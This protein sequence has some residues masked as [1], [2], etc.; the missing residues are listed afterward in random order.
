[1]LK[2][3]LR[4]RHCRSQHWWSPSSALDAALS[5]LYAS[6]HLSLTTTVTVV[7]TVIIVSLQMRKLRLKEGD[8]TENWLQ[9]RLPPVSS[10]PTGKEQLLSQNNSLMCHNW[11]NRGCTEERGVFWKSQREFEKCTMWG[12]FAEAGC[13]AD[14]R[15]KCNVSLQGGESQGQGLD[16][17]AE[18]LALSWFTATHFVSRQVLAGACCCHKRGCGEACM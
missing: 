1:M 3:M 5:A 11:E 15:Q 10:Q 17:C 13:H 12:S 9:L 6:V 7:D 14:L 2:R 16:P 4:R 8:E 18:H